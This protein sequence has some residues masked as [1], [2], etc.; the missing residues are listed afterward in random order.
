MSRTV[1]VLSNEATQQPQKPSIPWW[2]YPNVL[3]LDAPIV[4][5]VWLSV[6]AKVWNVS[7]VEPMLPV[8]LGLFVW[9]VYAVDRL[10]DCKMKPEGD[11]PLRHRFHQAHS[12]WFIIAICIAL[13]ITAVLSLSVLQWSI[14]QTALLPVIATAAFFIF[15]FFTTSGARVSYAKNFLAGYAFAWGVG[16]GLVGLIGHS[17]PS[18]WMQLLVLPEMLVFGLLCAINV[19]AV[20]LWVKGSDELDEEADEWALTMPLLVLA[21]F[22]IVLMR[23]DSYE[24]KHAFY[25]SILVAVALMYVI[26]RMRRSMSPALLRMSADLILLLA[27][28]VHYLIAKE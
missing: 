11:F 10:L 12:R 2:L 9:T 20:D 5:V 1:V 18:N 28:A 8:V 22:C 7:Y 14:V 26:N 6:F 19:T 13:I 21:F 17:L 3:S 24:S 15:S 27:A 4:A 16:C 25:I 23:A